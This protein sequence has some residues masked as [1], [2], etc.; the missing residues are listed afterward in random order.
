MKNIRRKQRGFTL[1]ELL[2]VIVI[3]AVIALIST[4]M[5]LGVIEKSKKGAI[6]DSAYGISKA[7]DLY[8]ASNVENGVSIETTLDVTD[9]TL[10]YKGKIDTSIVM[11]N[12]SGKS[13]I[14]ISID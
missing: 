3:I 9:G 4:P 11:F 2:A 14:I 5:I 6:K 8:Y 7:A 12:D 13:K 1:I 10:N